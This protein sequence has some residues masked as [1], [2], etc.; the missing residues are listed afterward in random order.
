[1][2]CQGARSTSVSASDVRPTPPVNVYICAGDGQSCLPAAQRP[3]ISCKMFVAELSS[4]SRVLPPGVA[5]ACSHTIRSTINAVDARRERIACCGLQP[6]RAAACRAP[7][8]PPPYELII[9]D[10]TAV[11][12]HIKLIVKY[13]QRNL[14]C[15]VYFEYNIST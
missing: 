8:C 14:T 12:V 11:Q 3:V 1:M 5:Q 13:L 6:T 9:E 2:R 7:V 15:P 4:G 10:Q